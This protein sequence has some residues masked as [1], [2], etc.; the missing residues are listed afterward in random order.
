MGEPKIVDVRKVKLGPLKCYLEAK[1]FLGDQYWLFLGIYLVAFLVA[2]FVPILLIGPAFAGLAICFLARANSQR[3]E[4]EYVFKGLDFF[5]PS[6]IVTLIYTGAILVLLLPFLVGLIVGTIL[7]SSQEAA[8][9]ILGVLVIFV[10]VVYWMLVVTIAMM[11]LMFATLLI[12]DKKMDAWP[13]T[14]L[15]VKGITKNF[16]GIVATASM[17]QLIYFVGAMLC[18]VPGV[19]ALPIILAGHF[20]AY[21]KIYGV[22][23]TSVVV[24]KPGAHG[25]QSF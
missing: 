10:A 6:V 9:L 21:W 5:A 19:L 1:E 13:A 14:M 18:I 2:G 7:I 4:F 23:A 12:V 20:I 3:V 24:A 11:Y 15:A 22:E 25:R 16:V 17:G 8:L